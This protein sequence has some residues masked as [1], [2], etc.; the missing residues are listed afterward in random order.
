MKQ[1]CN[2]GEITVKIKL[3]SFYKIGKSHLVCQDYTRIVDTVNGPALIVSDGCSANNEADVAARIISLAAE[4]AIRK[5]NRGGLRAVDFHTIVHT[6]MMELFKQMYP[7]TTDAF[8]I[9]NDMTATLVAAYPDGDGY[10]NI[11]IIG[12][13]YAMIEYS[14]GKINIYNIEIESINMP[15]FLSYKDFLHVYTDDDGG[16]ISVF[17]KQTRAIK[18]EFEDGLFPGV[19]HGFDFTDADIISNSLDARSPFDFPLVYARCH[20]DDIRRIILATDG[21]DSYHPI[22]HLG[23]NKIPAEQILSMFA[24]FDQHNGVYLQRCYNVIN[25]KTN[26]AG[27]AHY[28]DIGMASL[29]IAE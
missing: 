23:G 1:D 2:S 28:D 13:G 8:S 3:D 14:T 21:V 24:G 6:R 19:K 22:N 16:K 11:F 5:I 12:D 10:Y 7:W 17:E 29:V 27:Y 26:A 20:I 18:K 9:I 4:F 15:C 25:T